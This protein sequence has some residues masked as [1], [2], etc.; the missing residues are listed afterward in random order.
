MYTKKDI[1]HVVIEIVILHTVENVVNL[2]K[3]KESGGAQTWPKGF[4]VKV[5][6]KR[7]LER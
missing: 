3:G 5:I 6:I 2:R 1:I 4:I 7:S